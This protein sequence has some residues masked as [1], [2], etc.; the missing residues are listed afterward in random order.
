MGWVN[1]HCWGLQPSVLPYAAR[2][3]DPHHA[4]GHRRGA[5]T[6]QYLILISV[7]TLNLG[8]AAPLLFRLRCI[9]AQA[10]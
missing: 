3:T 7:S 6:L 8:A 1:F 10:V 4:E 5:E 9:R 2:N